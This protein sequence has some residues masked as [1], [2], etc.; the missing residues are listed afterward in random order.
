MQDPIVCHSLSL[1]RGSWFRA[2]DQLFQL[3][4]HLLDGV[5][6]GTISR[7]KHHAGTSGF[8]GF[9]DPGDL[10]TGQIVSD[11]DIAGRERRSEELLDLGAE[12]SSVD[13]SVQHQWCHDPI[14]AQ[15][16]EERGGVPMTMRRGGDQPFP[17][18]RPSARPG[19]VGFG[20]GFVEKDQPCGIQPRLRFPPAVTRFGDVCARLFSGMEGPFLSVTPRRTS[21]VHISPMLTETPCVSRS[22]ARSSSRVAS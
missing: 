15:S 10:V 20:P 3:R 7:Q 8:D 1:V 4:E 9:A 14:V 11:H 17:A 2:S 21:V 22:Q 12:G 13:R 16:R 18:P 19:H 5:Q 6:V